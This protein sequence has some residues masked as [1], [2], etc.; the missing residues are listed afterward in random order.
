[1]KPW[2]SII[3]PVYNE[4][5]II[6]DTLRHLPSR[7][8]IEIIIADGGSEDKTRDI[9]SNLTSHLPSLYL[10][11]TPKGRARQMNEGANISKGDILLFLHGDCRLPENA[12]EYIWDT[13]QSGRYVAGAFDIRINKRGLFFRITEKAANM[14]SRYL[15]VIYGDQAMFMKRE[16]FFRVGGFPVLP[17]MEDIAISKRLKRLG[18]FRFIN[19]PVI[20]SARRWEKEGAFYT[21]FRDI[22]LASAYILFNVSPE[23]LVRYYKDVR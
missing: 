18:R 23:K 14:R 8:D 9:I 22:T 4:E 1:M 6:G 12:L 13:I 20:V 21:M 2:L 16:T 10:I 3:M 17:L 19:T 11:E 15:R 5:L 7:K